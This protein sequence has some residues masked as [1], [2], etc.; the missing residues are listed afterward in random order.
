M[1]SG[2]AGK[3]TF[4]KELGR[5][6]GLP[7]IHLD[8][9][10]WRPG[11][12]ETPKD[13]WRERQSE[14]LSGEQWI[15]DGNYAAT[16]DLRFLRADTIIVLAPSRWRCTFRALCRSLTNRG[17]AILSPGCPER[18][19]LEFLLWVWRYPRQTR[20]LLDAALQQLRG[21]TRLVELETSSQV[22]TFL[23]STTS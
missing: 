16:Y 8:H 7:V 12:M 3:T 19:D 20:P 9:L 4:A 18:F 23:Q 10:Y 17:R 22:R 15:V 14:H 2:G 11:W 6:T 13:V 5:R 21:D 1:G